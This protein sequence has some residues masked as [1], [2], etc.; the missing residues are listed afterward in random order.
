MTNPYT[1][2][3]SPAVAGQAPPLAEELLITPGYL[4]SLRIPLV[5]GRDFT[6]ADRDGAPPVALVNQTLARRHF[7]GGAVGR[8]LQTGEPDPESDKL[9]IVGVVA[10]VKFAG[11]DADPAPTIYVPYAQHTWWRNL[12]L[13]VSASGDPYRQ[14]DPVRAELAALDP[15]IPFQEVTT[16]RRLGREAV[17]EPRFQALLLG[18]FGLV[19]LLLATAGI[20]GL[21][22]YTVQQRR[23]DTAVR[24]ALG[25]RPAQVVG[26]VLV[27]GLRLAAAGVALGVGGSLLAT[28]L[29]GGVL[30][31]VEAIDP[32]T[33]ASMVGFLVAVTLAACL[34]PARRAARTDPMNVL[35]SE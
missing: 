1:P 6:A 25:A 18:S 12:Y 19:A 34:L 11:P 15:E 27:L 29:I 23:R 28:R 17:S 24:L 10:D 7:P 4:A 22:S 21:V 35:R 16:L 26:G 3:G 2:E 5:A 33:F 31:E 32:L 14:L 30:F 13:V 20:Y 9:T 8:W